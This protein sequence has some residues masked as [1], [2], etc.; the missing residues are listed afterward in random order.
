MR[1]T[2]RLLKTLFR[3]VIRRQFRQR[4]N[5]LRAVNMPVAAQIAAAMEEV[6]DNYLVEDERRWVDRI[7]SLRGKLAQS[8]AL[9]SITDFGAG[10]ATDQRSE[11]QMLA[12][13][14]KTTTIGEA[15]R[16]S[17]PYFWS[18]LLFKL[19]RKLKPETVVELGTCLGISAAYQAAAQKLNDKGKV[20]T[21]EGAP[22]LADL[23]QQHLRSLGLDNA[24]VVSGRFFD[25][26][27]PTLKANAPVDYAFIDGHHDE[28]ATV[29]YFEQFRPH[30]VDGAVLIFDDISWS[31]GMRRAWKTL[32]DDPHVAL[33]IDLHTI[34]ICVAKQ[35]VS[36]QK[37]RFS[38]R[39][40]V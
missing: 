34:G 27:E 37:S 30:L 16:Y 2:K 35:S 22:A 28:H 13:V 18:L 11:E 10:D 9:V 1:S 31:P 3:P 21:L 5:Q 14:V 19:V 15:C 29:A 25:T 39:M 32:E 7:E 26:L 4:L 36:Q 38:A 33:S 12:G 8:K 24:T 40:P 17:K 6:V 23:S 20:L